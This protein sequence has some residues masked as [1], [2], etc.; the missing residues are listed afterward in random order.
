MKLSCAV[1]MGRLHIIPRLPRFLERYP[2]VQVSLAFSDGFVDLIE[3]GIDLALRVGNLTDPSLIARR[4]GLTRRVVVATPGYIERHG[5]PL[6]PADLKDHNCIVYGGLASRSNWLFNGRDGPFSVPIAGRCHVDST[7]ALR[8]AILAG[9]GIG[10]APIWHFVD[11]EIDNGT[12]TVLLDDYAPET[13]PI[14]AVYTTKR[15]LAPKIR[16]MIDFLSDEFERDPSFC[17]VAK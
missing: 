14:H 11:G 16:A 8:A 10:V 2:D 5:A 13:H 9:I 4:I 1:V 12:L 7:E 15:F 3:G 17:A 6:T